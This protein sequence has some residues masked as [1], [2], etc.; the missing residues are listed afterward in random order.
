M[1][2][3]T[4][5]TPFR[6]TRKS[7]GTQKT[8]PEEVPLSQEP[9]IPETPEVVVA[10]VETRRI[11]QPVAALPVIEEDA[12]MPP[13]PPPEPSEPERMYPDLENVGQQQQALPM[14][15][16]PA[17]PA[18]ETVAPPPVVHEQPPAQETIVVAAVPE[19]IVAPPINSPPPPPVIES[20]PV[21]TL[22]RS[23]RVISPERL[24]A[25]I[26]R[27]NDV[28]ED[29]AEEVPETQEIPESPLSVPATQIVH[30]PR[31]LVSEMVEM[32]PPAAKT[33][34]K[35]TAKTP[36]KT[37]VRV[38]E[39][40]ASPATQFDDS[41]R[42]AVPTPNIRNFKLVVADCLKTHSAVKKDTREPRQSTTQPKPP[43]TRRPSQTA[44][45]NKMHRVSNCTM[46]SAEGL[47]MLI[48]Y[49]IVG[50]RTD[51]S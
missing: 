50:L 10:A 41:S 33:P 26:H 44:G 13:P 5:N 51:D 7:I 3:T 43:T 23:I 36:A 25:I 18:I 6:A 47:L 48:C 1:V 49:L 9:E 19:Q 21:K 4:V 8:P 11:T 30:T 37:P 2:P 20:T 32:P 27:N 39:T 12:D 34:T 40:P 42:F 16:I 46:V 24:M 22:R 38:P 31:R 45:K 15:V 28:T 29:G 14:V 35:T 17:P